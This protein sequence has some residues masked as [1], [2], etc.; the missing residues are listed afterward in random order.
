MADIFISYKRERRAAAR[1]LEQ[2]LLRYGYSVWF[3]LELVRGQ[4][5]EAQIE[6]ELSAA[7]AVIVL[8]CGLS[9]KSPGVRS[10]ANRAKSLGKLIPL[11][12]EPCELPLFSTLEQNIDL[13]AAAGSPRD[14]AFDFLLDDLERLVGRAP[15]PDFKSLRNY[16]STWRTMGALPLARFPLEP[17]PAREVI[18]RDAVT[19]SAPIIAGPAHDYAFWERQWDKQGAGANLVALRAIAEDAPRYFADQARVRIA[20]IEATQ[21][22]QAERAQRAR[23]A[24]ARKRVEQERVQR[25]R[26]AAEQ[27]DKAEGRIKVDTGIVHVATGGWFKPGAGK[28]EWFKDIDTGPEM[29]VVPA[30]PPF[31][32]GRF[33]LTFEEW[34][35]A[36]AHPEW[37][38]HAH[39]AR[40]KPDDHSW[41]RGR[42][43]AI[44]VS[45]DDA[46]AYC[47]WLSKVTSKSYRLPSEAEWEL[48]C[49]A[50]TTTEFWW[51]DQ[52]STDQANYDGSYPLSN[53]KRGEYRARTVAV[54]SFEPNPWGLYQ[55]HGNVLEWCEDQVGESYRVLRGG[56]W[57]SDPAGL[58]SASRGRIRPDGRDFTAGFRVART[59]LP[60]AP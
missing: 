23:E 33:A 38:A 56:S 20:E 18:L 14:H 37:Q 19:A 22:Q 32:I 3:D 49:R 51:G 11:I 34:D 55:V 25:K 27:G 9:V 39:M 13:T 47:L 2:I 29:V 45:W 53:G 7:K 42:Q 30:E 6:R 17:G 15:Q 52:I 8:W 35:A 57:F 60:P 40:R 43:P 16:E 5:F 58:R 54:D 4:D 12:I 31:A 59:L 46:K 10:E 50:G 26:A 24:E 41:G 36:Q 44:D 28:V 48:C 21:R 1:H